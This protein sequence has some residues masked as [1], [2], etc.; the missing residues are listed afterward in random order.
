MAHPHSQHDGH[1][2]HHII[3]MK[4]LL[5]VFL[6]LVGLTVLTVLTAEGIDIGPFNIV[7]ALAIAFSKAILVL[8]FF[9]ALKYDNRVNTLVFSIGTIFVAVFLIFTLFDTA[10][11]GD[12]DNV[13]ELTIEDEQRLEEAARARESALG[14]A[15]AAATPAPA[16]T[17]EAAPADTSQAPPADTTNAETRDDGAAN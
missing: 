7:L 3:P 10:F 15:P 13:N 11:R 5:T 2:G 14:T 17:S 12:L 16:D 9:M 8:T 4:V 1:H 6:S